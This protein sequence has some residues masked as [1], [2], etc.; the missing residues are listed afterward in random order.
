MVARAHG[1]DALVIEKTCSI[2]VGSVHGRIGF[3]P[4]LPCPWASWWRTTTMASTFCWP[5]APVA[6]P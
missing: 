5:P 2:C 3:A 1:L 6:P 4:A